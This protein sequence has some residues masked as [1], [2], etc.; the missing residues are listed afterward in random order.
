MIR[1]S[2]REAGQE[3]WILISQVEHARLS[4]VLAESWGA[5]PYAPID[6]HEEM[7][8]AIAR[9]DD[10]WSAWEV[11]P[12]VDAETGRP[13]DFTETPLTDSLAIWRESIRAGADIGPLAGYMVSG[14]FSTLLERFSHCWKSDS[15]LTALARGFLFEQQ[16]LRDKWLTMWQKVAGCAVDQIQANQAVAWLQM[17]DF[18]SLWL[19][20]GA[21]D[22]AE[23]FAPPCGPPLS[24]RPVNGP[25]DMVAS[26]WPFTIGQLEVE[27]VGRSI[28]AMQYANPSDLVTASAEAVS[29]RWT[30][31][32]DV[33]R[34]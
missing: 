16:S 15:Y 18:A 33:R 34:G 13:L 29:L 19:C 30:L 5:A 31:R 23:Q 7:V 3:R 4:G 2:D 28:P 8:A 1:R 11:S 27:V 6:P 9:H 12:K 22:Q 17:F 32:P 24:I 25:Y 21:R 20:C 10:G 26:P 14:H